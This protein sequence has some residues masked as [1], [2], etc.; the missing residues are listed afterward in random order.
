MFIDRKDAGQQLGQAL[1]KYETAHPILV[2]IPRGG[3]KVGYYAALKLNCDFDVIVV[4]KL[5]YPRQPEAAFGAIAEDGSLYLDPW[6]NR[7]LS[8]QIIEDVIEMEQIEIERRIQKFRNGQPLVDISNR[9]VILVD[10][11]IASGSTAFAA[12]NMCKKREPKKLIFAAPIASQNK[13]LTL[14]A[15]VDEIVILEEWNELLAVS[16][17]YEKFSNLSD[18]QVQHYLGRW[19]EEKGEKIPP[20]S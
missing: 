5:G 15:K 19:Q 18:K 9:V 13:A 8:K 3:V 2:G 17:A 14:K 20:R 1:Q 7:Y 11:G 12:I 4:R 6:S 16:Q 10:D